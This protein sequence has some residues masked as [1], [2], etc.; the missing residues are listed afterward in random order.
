[1]FNFWCQ[2][3]FGIFCRLRKWFAYRIFRYRRIDSRFARKY[4]AYAV[5]DR[6]SRL[7]N[8]IWRMRFA[9]R[10]AGQRDLLLRFFLPQAG[11]IRCRLQRS[12][13]RRSACTIQRRLCGS[14]AML[15]LNMIQHY[16]ARFGGDLQRSSGQ[17]TREH[18][19][20]DQN[21]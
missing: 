21:P 5:L 10:H 17:V 4:S 16:R 18:N 14:P 15:L 8:S 19:D 13:K 11:Q 20:H 1:M 2:Q 9:A 3:L 6:L 7:I 12:R